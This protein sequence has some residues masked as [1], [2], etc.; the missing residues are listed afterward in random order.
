MTPQS[1][2]QRVHSVPP[3]FYS[4]VP[5]ERVVA[6]S[7][8]TNDLRKSLMAGLPSW[9]T[10]SPGS[11]NAW[12]VFLGSS[13]GNSPG[14]PWNYD[15][16]PSIG[17]AHGGVAEYVDKKGYWNRIRKYAC[18]IFPELS[19]SNAYAAT[20]VRNLV[21]DQSATAPKVDSIMYPAALDVTEIL[22]KLIRPRLV[23]ALGGVRRYTDKAFLKLPGTEIFDRGTLFTAHSGEKR[24]W[25]S[26]MSKWE[27]GDEFLYVSPS[28]IHPSIPHI[29]L[30]D[31]LE[32]LSQQSKVA[33]DL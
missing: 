29:S 10:M 3:G 28:G 8:A 18:T 14:D 31:T 11:L 19:P 30:E 22:G 6:L 1:T 17:V 26:L 15:P 27:S 12:L 25:C 16:L 5:C 24:Q 7:Y 32:F 33:R 20:M 4:A 2:E 9:P 13:P 23:I 21:P